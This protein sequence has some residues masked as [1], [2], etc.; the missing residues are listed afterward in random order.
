MEASDQDISDGYSHSHDVDPTPAIAQDADDSTLQ[1]KRKY[2]RI[3]PSF[4]AK[5][6]YFGSKGKVIPDSRHGNSERAQAKSANRKAPYSLQVFAQIQDMSPTYLMH[7]GSGKDPL[8]RKKTGSGS[9]KLP[10]RGQFCYCLGCMFCSSARPYIHECISTDHT[11]TCSPSCHH[12]PRDEEH[13]HDSFHGEPE[14]VEEQEFFTMKEPDEVRYAGKLLTT[15]SRVAPR[16]MFSNDCDIPAA[17]YAM[18]SFNT[19]KDELDFDTIFQTGFAAVTGIYTLQV[20]KHP[21]VCVCV[22]I[23]VCVCFCMRMYVHVFV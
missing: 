21:S 2:T 14:G 15:F 3:D 16:L 19:D 23:S 4:G 1:K 6:F 20:T 8:Q 12:C 7:A 22:Y 13:G 9:L 11:D 18:P 17:M 5:I 10:A